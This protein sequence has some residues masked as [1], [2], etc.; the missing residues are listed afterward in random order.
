M[1]KNG[2]SLPVLKMDKMASKHLIFGL[3]DL[4]FVQKTVR[5]EKV[6]IEAWFSTLFLGPDK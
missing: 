3:L 6:V 2:L 4:D 5:I 1:P